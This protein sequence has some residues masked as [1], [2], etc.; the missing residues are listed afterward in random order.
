VTNLD[1][2]TC[3]IAAANR[4]R[5]DLL[6]AASDMNIA[7][8][9]NVIAMIGQRQIRPARRHRLDARQALPDVPTMTESGY[10]KLDFHPD[11]WQAVVAP[12]GTPR[13]S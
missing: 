12:I 10:H 1:L 2:V 9:S 7:P 5:I 3:P 11:I 13:R 6:A 8:V 4:C